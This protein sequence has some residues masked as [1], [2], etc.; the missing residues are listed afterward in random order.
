MEPGLE[1]VVLVPLLAE[2]QTDVSE[3][4][5]PRK[6][7]KERI[8]NKPSQVY[9]RDTRGKRDEGSYDG[10][11]P[12]GEDYC[13]ATAREPSVGKVEIVTRNQNVAT[14]LFNERPSAVHAGP[15][16]YERS[17]DTPDGAGYGYGQQAESTGINQVA[18]EGH[19]YFR[20]Q[21][22]ACRL[23]SHQQDH[24]RITKR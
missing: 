20:R 19:Y 17:Q 4:Q 22:Y 12:A 23:D 11:Q 5:T 10:Q 24:A 7:A 9:S 6:R 16:R 1:R 14:I 3:T 13:L 21:R 8:G 18:R 15:I 2:F